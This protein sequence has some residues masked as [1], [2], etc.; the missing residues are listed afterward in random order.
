MYVLVLA[1]LYKSDCNDL[2]HFYLVII[3]PVE[4]YYVFSRAV[5]LSV[6]LSVTIHP[7][8]CVDTG[9]RFC[10]LASQIKPDLIQFSTDKTSPSQPKTD[11][12]SFDKSLLLQCGGIH[13][14]YVPLVEFC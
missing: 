1:E 14:H 8:H 12:I 5:C 3:F 2:L 9:Y 4:G 11:D 13:G 10:L 6:C 7:T